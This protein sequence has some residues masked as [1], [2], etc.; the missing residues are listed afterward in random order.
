LRAR[1]HEAAKGGLSLKAKPIVTLLIIGGVVVLTIIALFRPGPGTGVS[2]SA[3]SPVIALINIDGVLTTGQGG[4]GSLLG[5]GSCGSDAI[6]STLSEVRQD[7]RVRAVVLRV[8]SPGGSAAAAQEISEELAALRQDGKVVVTSMGDTA[9]SGAYWIAANTD[10][11]MANA[12]TMTGSIGVIWQVA[13]YQELYQKLGIQ[14]VTFTSGPYKDMG[15]TSRQLTEA[16][17]EI[18]AAMIDDI[19][20][21]FVDTV[22][23]G[24][25]MTR[26]EVLA[27]ADGRI[28]TGNQALAV[29]LVDSLGGLKKAIAKAAELAGVEGDYQVREFGRKSAWEIFLGEVR[30]ALRGLGALGGLGG[31]TSGNAGGSGEGP[32]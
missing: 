2:L 13:N 30:S 24:R 23:A 14:Y 1:S 10:H 18:M 19:Y 9:A 8:N 20:G 3:G 11:I 29:G 32:K 22:T 5:Q 4:A 21:Q 12:A 7:P 25:N 28:F 6:V 31:L 16:E 27:L 17:K 15:S 26:E